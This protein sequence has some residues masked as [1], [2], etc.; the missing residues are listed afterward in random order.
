MKKIIAYI[1]TFV[2][3]G[4]IIGCTQLE[5]YESSEVLPQPTAT[6]SVSAVAD[7]SFTLDIA[8]DKAGILGYALLDDTAAS[9]A[10]IS[11][12]SQSISGGSSTVSTSTFDLTGSGNTTLHMTGLMPNTYYK[13]VV[14]SSNTDG[15]ES[16]VKSM[17]IKTDDGVG[18]SLVSISPSRSLDPT[19]TTG[20]NVVLTF[21][22]PIGMVDGS[23]FTFTYYV[24]GVE[25]TAD[26]AIIDP[27]DNK[28]VTVVQSYNAYAGDYVFLSFGNAA[29]AD[30]SG[31]PVSE[32]ASGV[33][34]GSPVGLYWRVE[35]IGW[36]IDVTTVVPEK[37][38]AVSDAQFAV[39][40]KTP[41][42]VSL[43]SDVEDSSVRFIVKVE[44][45]TTIYD[46]PAANLE[47]NAADS[48]LTIYKPFTPTYGEMVYVEIDEGVLLDEFD[49]PNN[50]IESG[51]DGIANEGDLVTEVGWL[52]SYG[53][54]RDLIIG[55][56][57]FSGVSYW[58]G[59]DESFN[60]EIVADPNDESKVIINGFYG[61]STPIP[62]TFNGDFATL[63]VTAEE[64]YL[65]GDLFADSGETYFWSYEESEFIMNIQPNGDLITDPYYWLALYWVAADESDEG[66]VNIFTSSTWTKTGSAAATKSSLINYKSEPTI[67]KG[68]P[69]NGIVK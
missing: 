56:Y 13:V 5:D 10:A 3:L 12:L 62:A 60:V 39:Q 41:F 8:S 31:N 20:F 6:L 22:E 25:M 14:A 53:Y 55:T 27:E 19:Q 66:W 48:T 24:E 43:S 42:P 36:D 38:T 46:V 45:K 51:I 59:A 29:V 30:L 65:L 54:T 33:V 69:R 16:E 28:K 61:S 40:L 2:A 4:Y 47:V 50:V 15:V 49:N 23:K 68:I 11:I 26:T 1:F 67:R 44:G 63:T 34:E 9:V 37:G 58:E 17:I 57:T 35:N 52:I 7:S 18:P 32:F 64:D 21:D